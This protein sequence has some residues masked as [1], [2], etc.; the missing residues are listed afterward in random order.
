MKLQHRIVISL[1]NILH[2]FYVRR[3]RVKC[4]YRF[5]E[6]SSESFYAHKN[7]IIPFVL[8]TRTQIE[9]MRYRWHKDA[10]NT[11]DLSSWHEIQLNKRVLSRIHNECIISFLNITW[12]SK[13]EMCTKMGLLWHCKSS[14]FHCL[15]DYILLLFPSEDNILHNIKIHQ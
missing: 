1:P 14:E 8:Y 15:F 4:I 3:N 9:R 12:A 2:L 11:Y 6:T 10:V 7:I 13:F 5:Y